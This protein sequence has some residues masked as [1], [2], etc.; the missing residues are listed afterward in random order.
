MSMTSPAILSNFFEKQWTQNH[1]Q[2]LSGLSRALYP[3]T[4]LKIAVYLALFTDPEGVS[5]FSIYQICWIKPKKKT[6][7]KLK[8]SL[9]RNFVH[10]L[11]TFLGFYQ[12][13]FIVLL[14]IQHE[15]N[16]LPTTQHRQAKVRRFLG[17]C[18]YDYFIYR[19]NFVFRK[20][21]ETRRHLGSG[22]KTVNS[23]TYSE[24]RQPIKT[25]ENCYSLIW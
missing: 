5:C 1:P 18:L 3:T 11:Q 17:I 10:N 20:C 22:R 19:T 25:R 12:V 14:Q 24:L 2:Y 16:F 21:V 9:S 8:T 15:N 4:V 23:Q 6:F 7:C 13:R